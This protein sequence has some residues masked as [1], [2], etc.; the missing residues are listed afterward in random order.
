[1]QTAIE[2]RT[3]LPSKTEPLKNLRR[4]LF[5]WIMFHIPLH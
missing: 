4:Y 5:F 1:L 2:K 3:V